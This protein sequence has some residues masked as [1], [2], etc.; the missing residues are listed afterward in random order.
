MA[1]PGLRRTIIEMAP[2]GPPKLFWLGVPGLAAEGKGLVQGFRCLVKMGFAMLLLCGPAGCRDVPS[3][4]PL[5][6]PETWPTLRWSTTAPERQ[7]IDSVKLAELLEYLRASDSGIHSLLLVRHGELV[8]D[9][10]FYPSDSSKPHDVASVTKSVTTSLLGIAIEDGAIPSLDSPLRAVLPPWN[11]ANS[12]TAESP[13]ALRDLA[14]MRTGLDCGVAPGE[15]ELFQ[16]IRSPDWVSFVATLP[17]LHDPGAEFAYCSPAMHLISEV[18]TTAAGQSTLAY[19]QSRLFGPLGIESGHWPAA[20]SGANHGWGDLRLRPQ[21]LA[22]LGLLYLHGGRW[23]GSQIVPAAWVDGATRAHSAVGPPGEGY[24]LGWW[25]HG[26]PLEGAFEANG[27][28][29]QI[30]LVVPAMDAVVVTTGAGF[31]PAKLQPLLGE[32]IVAAQPLAPNKAG[33]ARL[34]ATI[35]AVGRGPEPSGVPSSSPL[36]PSVSGAKFWL[37]DNALGFE[38]VSIDFSDATQAV[39]MLRVGDRL[40]LAFAGDV[41]IPFGLD[42]RY[43]VSPNGIG[44]GRPEFAAMGEWRSPRVF[45]GKYVDPAA[46]TAFEMT[47]EFE[48]D[49]VTI[50]FVDGSELTGDHTLVGRRGQSTQAHES[51]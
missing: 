38:S 46:P 40:G 42:G 30:V 41:Q 31:D 25:T 35:A 11:D 19:A 34:Q 32:A 28:G 9:A 7:G 12:P 16:M 49:G 22:K 37:Q 4:A 8:L 18:I 3:E 1:S 48:G 33:F 29:G 43:L 10:A 13:L 2:R 26:G 47:F 51:R 21:D 23:D 27:R 45:W 5:I 14:A 6:P 24:G 50:D 15:R 36:S 44:I 17:R 39:L 20:K